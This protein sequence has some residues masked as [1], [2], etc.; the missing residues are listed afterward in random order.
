MHGMNYYG[1]LRLRRNRTRNDFP[2]C[3][4]IIAGRATTQNP[5]LNRTKFNRTQHERHLLHKL[6]PPIAPYANKRKAS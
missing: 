2:I 5:A 1:M 4:Q 3:V 6:Q